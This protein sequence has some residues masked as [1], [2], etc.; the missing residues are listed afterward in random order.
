MTTKDLF[1][2]FCSRRSPK[3]SLLSPPPLPPPNLGEDDRNECQSTLRAERCVLLVLG[4]LARLLPE[5][6][7]WNGRLQAL[8]LAW[9]V[10]SGSTALTSKAILLLSVGASM[11]LAS[12]MHRDADRRHRHA[13]RGTSL[14]WVR[15]EMYSWQR[16]G[17][18]WHSQC[19]PQ[20][21][22]PSLLATVHA[23]ISTACS[24]P[25]TTGEPLGFA[26]EICFLV[27]LSIVMSVHAARI[28]WTVPS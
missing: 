16:W 4:L 12:G 14:I 1:A 15:P 9:P 22:L 27:E 28:S 10:E 2:L 24:R 5:F 11:E 3:P 26:S 13:Q 21:K 6:A 20:L 8:G 17:C 25:F 18:H 23:T 19:Q 7:L